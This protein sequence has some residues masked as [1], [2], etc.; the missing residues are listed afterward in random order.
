[1][2]RK[3]VTKSPKQPVCTDLM[4]VVR[5]TSTV[6]TDPPKGVGDGD[7]PLFLGIDIKPSFNAT[8]RESIKPLIAS[9]ALVDL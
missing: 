7:D 1:M 5:S 4:G 8:N 6:Y 2:D 3:V 9:F